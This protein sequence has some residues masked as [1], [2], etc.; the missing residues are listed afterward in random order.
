M[1]PVSV[2]LV[3]D[4]PFFLCIAARFLRAHDEVD[5]VGTAGGGEEG[6]AQAQIL[7]P[8]V[9]LLDLA[10]PG[11]S[12]LEVIPR[13]RRILPQVGIVVLTLQ[14]TD[15]YREAALAAGAD[16]FIPKSVMNTTLLPVIH[17]VAQARRPGEP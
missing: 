3:D 9:V 10:M 2:L 1:K 12:G 4:S 16:D 13:L 15:S 11:L 8:Q 5:L 17:R 7:R 14:D 6:L